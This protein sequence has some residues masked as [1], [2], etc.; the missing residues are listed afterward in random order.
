VLIPIANAP[1]YGCKSDNLRVSVGLV[2]LSGLVTDN[3]FNVL[4]KKGEGIKGLYAVGNCLGRRYANAYATSCSG[5]LDRHG[6][7]SRHARRRRGRKALAVAWLIV[8]SDTA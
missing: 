1:F 4:D 3:D 7:D 5:Q 8:R 6:H 2:T